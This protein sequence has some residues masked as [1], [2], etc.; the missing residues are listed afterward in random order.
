MLEHDQVVAGG[1]AGAAV[2]DD[3]ARAVYAGL[4]EA[5]AQLVDR[6]Q[7]AVGAEVLAGVEAAGSGDVARAGVD[8][9]GASPR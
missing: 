2:G 8:R 3:R 9:V 1:H 5:A 7:T 6:E 4:R